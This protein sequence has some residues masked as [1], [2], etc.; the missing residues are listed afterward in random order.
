MKPA[1]HVRLPVEGSMDIDEALE[2]ALKL[3][4]AIMDAPA[5]ANM[6]DAMRL[7][8]AV[9]SIDHWL[10]KKK[11]FLPSRWSRP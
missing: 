8:E 10:G 6:D 9:V 11:G 4:K 1:L 3:A 2:T 5:G 7:A